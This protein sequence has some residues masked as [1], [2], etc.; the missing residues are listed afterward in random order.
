MTRATAGRIISPSAID[1]RRP[2]VGMVRGQ[3]GRDMNTNS[4][5]GN[6]G[7]FKDIEALV[8]GHD[9][10]IGCRNEDGEFVMISAGRT[11]EGLGRSFQVETL[12]NNGWCCIHT[13][14]EDGTKEETFDGKWKHAYMTPTQMLDEALTAWKDKVMRTFNDKRPGGT[15][16]L[17]MIYDVDRIIADAFDRDP[18]L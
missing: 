7:S 2:P 1:A 3:K 10:P 9:L 11:E 8:A 18:I 13:Y 6:I 16:T 5:M 17:R 15:D 12:Q 4:I 14:W